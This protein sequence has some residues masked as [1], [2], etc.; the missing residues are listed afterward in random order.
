[1]P[2]WDCHT[3]SLFETFS[4]NIFNICQKGFAEQAS[5]SKSIFFEIKELLHQDV[6]IF[7]NWSNYNSRWHV[8]CLSNTT[9]NLTGLYRNVCEWI[10]KWYL[11]SC[12]QT[13]IMNYL[14]KQKDIQKSKRSFSQFEYDKL[15]HINTPERDKRI[16]NIFLKNSLSICET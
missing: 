2:I 5:C 9:I 15:M 3:N 1:M 12:L 11:R 6:I 4:I 13:S 7:S 14:S 8:T 10:A 16:Y